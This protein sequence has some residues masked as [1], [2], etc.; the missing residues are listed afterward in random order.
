MSVHR[1]IVLNCCVLLEIL[2]YRESHENGKSYDEF[3]SKAVQITKLKET[4]AC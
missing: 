4:E 1:T 2:R 3:G